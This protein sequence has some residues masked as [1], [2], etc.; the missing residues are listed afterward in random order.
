MLFKC[1]LIPDDS[2]DDSEWQVVLVVENLPA[3]AGDIRDGGSIPGLERSPGGGYG[4]PLQ[5]SCVENPMDRGSWQATVHRVTKSQTR[6]KR[7]STHIQQRNENR[8]SNIR[9]TFNWK[10]VTN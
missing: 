4:N 6:L 3:N 2:A 10:L 7:L 5:Y 9:H 1:V 8:N